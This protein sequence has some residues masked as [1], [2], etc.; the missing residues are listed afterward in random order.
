MWGNSTVSQLR[1]YEGRESDVLT[2]I[3]PFGGVFKPGDIVSATD[4]SKAWGIIVGIDKN[5]VT[6]LW[7]K[8]PQLSIQDVIVDRMRRN[9]C[10]EE[11]TMILDSLREIDK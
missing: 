10:D 6:V 11:D 7:S 8:A 4:R 9:I 5:S 3:G 2:H 1:V